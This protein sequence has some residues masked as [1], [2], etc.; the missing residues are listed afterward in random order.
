MIRKI[1]ASTTL[2]SMEK[3]IKNKVAKVAVPARDVMFQALCEFGANVRASSKGLK[4]E[5]CYWIGKDPVKSIL[6]EKMR[7][8]MIKELE[9]ELVNVCGTAKPSCM[10]RLQQQFKGDLILM[11]LKKLRGAWENEGAEYG[12]A[13]N[14][15]RQRRK[16]DLLLKLLI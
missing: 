11:L 9:A 6:F 2:D 8:T 3:A 7:D 5:L 15:V 4:F 13:R 12:Q 14:W 16:K 10:I 1:L